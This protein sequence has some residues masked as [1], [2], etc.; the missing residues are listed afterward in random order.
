[1]ITLIA[2]RI[3][4]SV[5]VGI[6]APREGVDIGR[7]VA[8]GG[9]D[10]NVGGTVRAEM[11]EQDGTPNALLEE[12]ER[13][14]EQLAGGA[15]EETLAWVVFSSRCADRTGKPAP[16]RCLPLAEPHRSARPKRG[17]FAHKANTHNSQ[18][19]VPGSFATRVR[20]EKLG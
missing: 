7:C 17:K 10:C 14:G 5:S 16:T 12:C 15:R 4:I 2:K 8:L 18:R 11:P 13:I 3:L 19:P 6:A 20:L 1:M 9:K